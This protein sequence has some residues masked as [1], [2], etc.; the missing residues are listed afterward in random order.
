MG[1]P[2]DGNVFITADGWENIKAKIEELNLNFLK[3]AMYRLKQNNNEVFEF[4]SE[5]YDNQ[6]EQ[7]IFR[8]DCTIRFDESLGYGYENKLKLLRSYPEL[9]ILEY[10]LRLNDYT[11]G[12]YNKK[13]FKD[14]KEAIVKLIQKVEEINNL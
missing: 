10:V 8:K 1:F 6:E 14:R 5:G 11:F 12:F 3:I 2:L 9:P 7:L 13:R 4:S